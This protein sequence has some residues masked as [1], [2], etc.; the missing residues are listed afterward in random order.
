MNDMLEPGE[1]NELPDGLARVVR[2]PTLIK[3]LDERCRKASK[4]GGSAF[5]PAVCWIV[6]DEASGHRDEIGFTGLE[7]L[8]HAIHE[9][10][11]VQLDSADI[12]ARFGLDSIGVILDSEGGD[13]NLEADAGKLKRAING[14][15]FEI[16]ENTIAAT[17]SIV[18][19]PVSE[20]L[21]PPEAN[22]VHAARAAERLSAEGGNRVEIGAGSADDADAPGKLLGQLTKALRDNSLK[23]VFQPLLATS[24]PE[25]ER[26]QLLPRL[27]GPDGTLIP[28]ARF[29]PVAAARGVLPA[30]DHWMI[31]HAIKILQ[32]RVKAGTEIPTLFLN[33]S[34]AIIDDEKFFNWVAEQV[35]SLQQDQRR[36]VF[37]FSVR[38]L[39]PRIR[40]AREV[41]AR[42]QALGIEVS[43]T[44]IDEK[45]PEIVLLKHLPADYLRMK[46]DFAHRVLEDE[47]LAVRFEDFAGAARAAGR[48]LIVPMLE[49][50]D[51]VSRIWQMDVDLIQGNFI[52]QPAEEPAE[53]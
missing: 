39:K 43:L 23:V 8:I 33:Q 11:R 31:A 5:P 40:E 41:L 6:L 44:A 35:E 25:K 51:E 28:A 16:G 12:T 34:P 13:R 21:R 52:Q 27:A 32:R 9:R 38:D 29:I 7:K 18:V 36:L 2:S 20:A 37:E 48:K 1:V 42:L 22:L 19:Q 17:A 3:Q 50:A 30:V 47:A 14:N 49:D 10:V 26:I 46:A 4:G 45:V 53:A 15:L 24:G